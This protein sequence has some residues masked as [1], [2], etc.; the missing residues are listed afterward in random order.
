MFLLIYYSPDLLN[1]KLQDNPLIFDYNVEQRVND[2]ITAA[3]TQVN[4]LLL[5]FSFLV[6]S[7]C[8]EL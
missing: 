5:D 8:L 3:I 4:S 1:A 7:F 6:L 2:F